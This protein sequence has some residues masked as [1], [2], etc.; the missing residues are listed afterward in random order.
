MIIL[1][2]W[3]SSLFI[4]FGALLLLLKPSFVSNNILDI[5]GYTLLFSTPGLIISGIVYLLIEKHLNFYHYKRI[6]IYVNVIFSYI[7]TITIIQSLS[8]GKLQFNPLEKWFGIYIIL[9]FFCSTVL[10]TLFWTM[11]SKKLR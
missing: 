8:Y 11:R 5:I 6:T 3:L 7:A 1:K 10:S 2:I 9:L 4:G